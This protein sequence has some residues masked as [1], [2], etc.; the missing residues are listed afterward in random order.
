MKA[1]FGTI[2]AALM[3]LMG[4]TTSPALAGIATAPFLLS[5]DD[6]TE[7]ITIGGNIFVNGSFP[8]SQNSNDILTGSVTSLPGTFTGVNVGFNIYDQDG[9]TLSDLLR[10]QIGPG[11]VTGTT[12]L[13]FAFTSRGENAPP[14]IPFTGDIAE[15][16]TETGAFQVVYSSGVA[17]NTLTVQ[18]RSDVEAVPEP[19]SLA[20]LGTAL[21][22]FGVLRRR[23]RRRV[24]REGALAVPSG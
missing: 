16:I 8:E 5:I 24:M 4:F 12:S 10:L 13:A 23:R 17:P 1:L 22:G 20:L 19:A 7:V 15:N 9:V 11:T 2:A 18:F 21:L 3:L 14:L 6:L